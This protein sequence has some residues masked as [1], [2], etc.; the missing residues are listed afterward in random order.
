MLSE[1]SPSALPLFRIA[2]LG[3][4]IDCVVFTNDSVGAF[5]QYQLRYP[6]DKK[7]VAHD[8]VSNAKSANKIPPCRSV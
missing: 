2:T 6:F 8:L 7:D 1:I 3:R 5:K 4:L